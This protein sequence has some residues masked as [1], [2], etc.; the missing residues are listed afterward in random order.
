MS[1]KHKLDKRRYDNIR[2]YIQDYH[3]KVKSL[4][5]LKELIYEKFGLE[6]TLNQITYFKGKWLGEGVLVEKEQHFEDDS[7]NLFRLLRK[8]SDDFLEVEFDQNAKVNM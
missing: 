3:D 8:N 7:L 2:A 1:H 6:Y 5:E 4:S